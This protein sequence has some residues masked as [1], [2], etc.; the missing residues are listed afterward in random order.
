[1][2]EGRRRRNREAKGS[3]GATDR[4]RKGGRREAFSS[5]G[6]L[7]TSQHHPLKVHKDKEV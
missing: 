2:T 3:E 6:S 7:G 5:G 1:V 4:E